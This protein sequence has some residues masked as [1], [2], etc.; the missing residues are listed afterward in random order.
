MSDFIQIVVGLLFLAMVYVLTR[1]GVYWRIKRACSST[2]KDLERR[3]AFDEESAV[4]LHYAKS[5]PFRIGMRDFRPKAVEYLVS[6]GIVGM[7]SE[8]KYYLKKRSSELNL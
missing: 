3:S 4:E 6:N 7:T 8:G 2:V 5:N 1:Y